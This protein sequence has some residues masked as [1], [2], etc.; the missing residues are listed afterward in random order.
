[1]ERRRRSS[2]PPRSRGWSGCRCDPIYSLTKHAVVGFVRSVAPQLAPI[3]INAICPG[4][5]DTPMLDQHD[6]RAR[7]AEAGFPLLQPDDVAEAM[8]LAATSEE[9]GSAGS[10]SRGA[11]LR[12]SASRTCPGPRRAGETVGLPPL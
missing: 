3:R 4:I 12:P 1:M 8:W 2:S 10:C 5:A 7:F 11:S 9:T 6:Q